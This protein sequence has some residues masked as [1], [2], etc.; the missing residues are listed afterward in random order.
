MSPRIITR[1]QHGISRKDLSNA[2]VRTLYGLKDAG[3]D[4]YLVGGGVRDLLLGLAPKDFDIATNATPEEIQKV[5]R[6]CRLVGRR[7]VIAHVRFGGEIIE[8]TTFR[9]NS[10][11]AGDRHVEEGGR[12][13]RDNVFGSIEDDAMRRDFTANAL[14]YNIAD[15]TVL[16]FCGAIEDMQQRQFRI[17]GDPKLRY[18]ED[19]VRMLRAARLAAKLDFTLEAQTQAAMADC[20]HLLADIPPARLFDEVQKLFLAGHAVKSFQEMLRLDLWGALFPTIRP[21]VLEKSRAF[22]ETAL[23]NT[24]ARL[25]QGKSV[26]P[27]FLFAA[28]GWMQICHSH[29][30]LNL[31]FEQRGPAFDR[32]LMDTADRVAL[33]RRFAVQV[34]EIWELQARLTDTTAARARRLLSNPRFRAAYDFLL[35]RAH[36]E[37]T[38]AEWAERWTRA[39]QPDA[40][41]DVLFKRSVGAKSVAIHAAEDAADASAELAAAEPK[42]RRQ[43]GP[44]KAAQTQAAQSAVDEN[45]PSSSAARARATDDRA[46]DESAVSDS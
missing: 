14:Y 31:S 7:F 4:A 1:D 16:D 42:K 30:P 26:T 8:V 24:D 35:L 5:F 44:R 3:F 46:S 18:V 15:F 20:Q 27:A 39:L 29:N 43:R 21:N 23:A 11:A 34:R 38:A 41:L 17:I 9:G 25:A 10:D 22:F 2:A 45:A 36:S 6:S 32:A 33:P 40:N 28:I 13:V 19:P 37:P 12:I